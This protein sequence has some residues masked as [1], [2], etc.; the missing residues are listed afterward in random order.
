MSDQQLVQT[1]RTTDTSLFS[2]LVDRYQQKLFYY[3]LKYIQDQDKAEDILQESFIK[4]YTNLNQY[5]IKQPFSPWAYRITHNEVINYCRKNRALVSLDQ[6]QWLSEVVNQDDSLA[7]K[8]DR[9][10]SAK[11]ISQALLKLKVK[12]RE[13]ILLYYFEKQDY[14]DIATVLQIPRSSVGT[15][16]RRAKAKLKVI[17]QSEM[18]S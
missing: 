11:Q 18:P 6:N 17:L 15:R 9:N 7:T 10:L 3:A 5:N 8:F 16:L 14:D 4:M 1:I 13:V 12:Y 2:M